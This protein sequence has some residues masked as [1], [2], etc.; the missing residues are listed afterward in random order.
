LKIFDRGLV[1]Q[2]F[3]P[4]HPYPALGKDGGYPRT[5]QRRGLEKGQ[6]GYRQSSDYN[7]LKISL[8]IFNQGDLQFKEYLSSFQGWHPFG[9]LFFL[10]MPAEGC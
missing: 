6:A 7:L 1:I 3:S 5:A 10:T 4:N 9:A 8:M 2:V